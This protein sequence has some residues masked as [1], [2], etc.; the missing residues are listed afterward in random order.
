MSRFLF[1][2]KDGSKT[3]GLTGS[4]WFAAYIFLWSAIEVNV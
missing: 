3:N 2:F 1:P 4:S